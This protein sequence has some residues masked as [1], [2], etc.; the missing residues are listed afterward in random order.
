MTQR[1]SIATCPDCGVATSGRSATDR[2]RP[3]GVRAQ[4][5]RER[6]FL[7][8]PNPSGLCHCGCKQK[9]RLAPRTD[10]KLGYVQGHPVRFIAGHNA[11]STNPR[12]PDPLTRYRVDPV[13]GCWIWPVRGN[14]RY[15]TI[16]E[17][18]RAEHAHRWFYKRFV[19][20]IPTGLHLDHLCRNPPCVN[21]GHLQPVT[22]AENVR[23]G[24]NTR[25]TVGDVRAIR[26]RQGT[27]TQREIAA[28]FGVT[29]ET[30]GM[31]F[32][33]KRWCDV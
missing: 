29:R 20:P 2:C 8:P 27:M 5:E 24:A 17:N 3:C 28:E 26:S 9:T 15:G 30:V 23:R 12:A 10:H 21:P 11:R 14:A 33:R 31:I 32:R 4:S 18:G 7:T 25:L 16:S 6:A 13:T 1:K 19:G 22:C